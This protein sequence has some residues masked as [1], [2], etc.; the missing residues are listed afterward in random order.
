[1]GLGVVVTV[2]GAA[3]D[4]L[5]QA[6]RIEVHERAGETT[7]FALRFPA[8]VSDG[9]FALLVDRRLDPESELSVLVPTRAGETCL[10]K[11]PVH[12]QQI[13]LEHGGAGSHVDVR[14]SDG[15]VAMDREVQSAIWDGA[16]S[17]AVSAIVSRYGFAPDVERTDALHPESKHTLV[18]RDS[19]LRFVRRLA[20]RNGCLFW[21]TADAFGIETAHFRPPPLDAEPV[22]E[23]AVNLEQPSLTTVELSWDVERPTSAEGQQL[24][25]AEKTNL[26][27]AA[28][29]SP[30][31]ALG[32]RALADIVA[33]PRSVHVAVPADDAGDLRARTEGALADAGWFVEASCST[34]V[35][36][37]GS[38]VRAADVVDLAGAGSRHSGRYFVT[39]VRHVIDATQHRMEL[40]LRRNGWNG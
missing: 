17:D 30:L 15:T 6:S 10:V 29:R 27:G 5:A 4:E 11:G 36:A 31:T 25:L 20:R 1:M 37:L 19:D 34:T 14:G 23:L 26:D 13:H 28:D 39:G 33:G 32:D 35:D 8:D 16:D 38:V 21:V 2:G 9:D 3:D 18:Q 40:E 22:A 12:A 24:E 7:T